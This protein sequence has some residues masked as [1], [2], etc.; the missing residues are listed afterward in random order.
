MVA[1]E[2]ASKNLQRAPDD[3]ILAKAREEGRTVLTMDLDFGYLLAIS[4]EKL[5]IENF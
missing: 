5:P 1:G 4:K 2:S 3:Q